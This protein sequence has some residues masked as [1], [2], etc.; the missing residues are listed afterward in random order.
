MKVCTACKVEKPLDAYSSNGKRGLR[1]QC[2]EC[3]N[4]A[5]RAKYA[6]DPTMKDRIVAAS[7]EHRKKSVAYRT[8]VDRTREQRKAQK[9]EQRRKAGALPLPEYKAAVRAQAEARRAEARIS[10][11]PDR[12][13]LHDAH[14]QQWRRERP[15]AAF[16]HRYRNDPEFNA[17][18]KLRARLRKLATADGEIAAYLSNA[19]KGR[20]M[21][22]AWQELLGYSTAQLVAH[23]KR[24]LPKRAT[25]DDFLTGRLHI[26]HIIPRSRFDLRDPD[27]VRRCWCL[28][29]LQ[30][31]WAEHNLAKRD[32]V[33]TLL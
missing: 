11:K 3:R 17:R 9:A 4:E 12:Q 21:W 30:L 23:L 22:K 16:K 27:E 15:G 32:R 7:R 5:K 10:I 24:T 26:D 29:N 28:S 25:W 13:T 18:Y 31:L 8:W 33:E 19:I 1:S 20:G 6:A 2:R 14:F